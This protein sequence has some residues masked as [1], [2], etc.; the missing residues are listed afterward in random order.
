MKN[1]L[2]IS[3]FLTFCGLNAQEIVVKRISGDIFK[4]VKKEA[5]TSKWKWK[6]NGIVGVNIAQGALSN[7]AAGGDNF[8][9]SIN[10]NFSYYIYHR[11]KRYTW[12]NSFD[13]NFGL[14]QATTLGSRKNDDRI[15]LLSKFGYKVDTLNKW[16]ASMLFNFRSQLFDGYNYSGS[17]STFSSSFLSPAY[18]I[19]SVGMDYKPSPKFSLFVS[20]LTSRWV[21]VANDYLS[22]KGAYGVPINKHS[23]GE[24]GAYVT[25]SYVNEIA[26]NISYRGRMDLFS[27]Y[28]NN[29]Q[30]VDIF[31]TNMFSFRI[32]KL[33]SATYNLDLIYDDDIKIFG[34]NKNAPR[35]QLKSLIGIGFLMRLEPK[36]I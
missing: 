32:N 25:M 19:L 16:Y 24:L 23:V 15:D 6:R 5:D 1:W 2:F 28:K 14:V 11:A 10:T 29:P 18:I 17:S 30:N 20:P 13:F 7:W 8:S 35:L 33:F 3:F 12:D 21:I 22:K 26:T 36:K 31:F 9:M 27:N 4:S 34:S